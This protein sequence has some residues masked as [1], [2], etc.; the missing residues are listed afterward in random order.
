MDETTPAIFLFENV[1]GVSERS[2]DD[3]GN[4]LEPAVQAI[5]F[6]RIHLNDEI[7]HLRNFFEVVHTSLGLRNG[8]G[9]RSST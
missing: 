3:D 1:V 6:K 7:L 8:V 2:S 4:K 9:F 5:C